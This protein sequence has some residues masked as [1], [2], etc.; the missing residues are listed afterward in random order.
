M[1]TKYMQTAIL[2]IL[3]GGCGTKRQAGTIETGASE[4]ERKTLEFTQK[5]DSDM[6]WRMEQWQ[7][8]GW[9]LASMSAK[10]PQPDGT[11][12]RR[13]ELF[14]VAGR[15][16]VGVAYDDRRIAR[17][18]LGE[19]TED[20]LLDWFGAPECRV[21]S[22]DRRMNLSWSFPSTTEH[23]SKPSGALKVSLAPDG[24][25]D[26]YSAHRTNASGTQSPQE[27]DF[28][29]DDR[30]IAKIGRG[31]TSEAQL[32]EWFGRPS[33]R[34]TKAERGAHLSWQFASN[35]GAEA[36]PSG[37]LDVRLAPDGK[38]DA[39]AAHRAADSRAP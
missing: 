13:A 8:D 2:C 37:E 28:K 22:A 20:E 4:P 21:W 30:T 26:F 31:E 23:S 15:S 25:V 18:S 27:V 36:H 33:E 38:V 19:T 11:I 32:L 1:K 14:R 10:L 7:H 12:H 17:I 34:E 24:K 3:I 6:N 9:G 29:Y 39:Y 5:S 35:T 16:P